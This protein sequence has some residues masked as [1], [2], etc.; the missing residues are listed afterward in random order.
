MAKLQKTTA[1]R[2]VCDDCNW[3]GPIRTGAYAD[4][5]AEEDRESHMDQNHPDEYVE[6]IENL[7]NGRNS[8]SEKS[9]AKIKKVR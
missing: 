6:E 3:K 2:A 7:E 5:E 1:Y 8:G 4:S 9:P